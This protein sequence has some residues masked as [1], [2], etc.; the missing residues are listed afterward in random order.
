MVAILE[1]KGPDRWY[2]AN[3]IKKKQ[4]YRPLSNSRMTSI[5]AD[6]QNWALIFR[7]LPIH[8]K[9]VPALRTGSRLSSQLH[10]RLDARAALPTAKTNGHGAPD[11]VRDWA[12]KVGRLYDE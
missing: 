5:L 1:I 10:G 12:I 4:S 3:S 7:S 11:I 6:S 8:D 2:V 9:L